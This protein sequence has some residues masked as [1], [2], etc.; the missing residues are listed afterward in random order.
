M[1]SNL[2]YMEL[3][4][5]VLVRE[6][7]SLSMVLVLLVPSRTITMSLDTSLDLDMPSISPTQ[8]PLAHTN[9]LADSIPDMERGVL[10]LPMALVLL[11]LSRTTTISGDTSLDLDM[12]STSFTLDMEREVL[13]LLVM[14]LPLDWPPG[15][16][17]LDMESNLLYGELMD[18]VLVREV[19]SLSMVLVLLV[20]SRTTTMSLDTSLD[21][22]MPSTSLTLD[23][24]DPTSRLADF[25]LDMEK[26]VL[27]L[28]A[29]VLLLPFRMRT[30]FLD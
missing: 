22:D 12:L 11:V 30:M 23:S 3:M 4:D 18:T 6:V 20:P 1:E 29:M 26:G 2:Q 10:S 13:S 25:T 24:A 14:V 16:L 7:L 9:R 5:T 27:S 17:L 21:L 15:L 28:L 8:E 19:L